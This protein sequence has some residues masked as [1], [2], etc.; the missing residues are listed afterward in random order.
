MDEKN[1]I[2]AHDKRQGK[3]FFVEKETG[4]KYNGHW[5]NDHYF[6]DGTFS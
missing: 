4:D 6:G 2:K 5:K 1:Y 3:G